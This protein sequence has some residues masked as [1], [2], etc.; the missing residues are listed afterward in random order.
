M[1]TQ[2]EYLEKS[3]AHALEKFGPDSASAKH[4]RT[5]LASLGSIRG[6]SELAALNSSENDKYHGTERIDAKRTEEE[7]SM[8]AQNPGTTPPP[9]DSELAG[10][11]DSLMSALQNEQDRFET[12]N[13]E[14]AKMTPE[15]WMKRMEKLMQGSPKPE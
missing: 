2:K 8:K 13:P 1:P 11:T 10:S 5:Q 12:D 9:Q 6:P 3:L 15:E 14:F 4:L 7:M